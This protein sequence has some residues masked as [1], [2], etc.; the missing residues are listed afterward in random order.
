MFLGNPIDEKGP[1]NET[2]RMPIH[3]DPPSF[4]EQAGGRDLLETGVKVI[5][6]IC[7]FCQGYRSF[8]RSGCRKDSYYA[9]TD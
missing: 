6:L 5:D 3:R 2:E 8:R 9:G 7:P 4:E 1:I